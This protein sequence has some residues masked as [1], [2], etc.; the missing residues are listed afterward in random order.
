MAL[1]VLSLTLKLVEC[2]SNDHP[3]YEPINKIGFGLIFGLNSLMRYSN[4]SWN[5]TNAQTLFEYYYKNYNETNIN[6][7]WELGNEPDIYPKQ[8]NYS[9]PNGTELYKDFTKLSE[10]VSKYDTD[11]KFQLH[12][13]DVT[14]GT[15]GLN[16]L[17]L[18]EDFVSSFNTNGPIKNFNTFTFHHQYP[19]LNQ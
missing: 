4:G 13:C 2:G 1:Q 17:Y 16:G 7:H 3:L 19:N 5:S 10:I 11:N 6:I 9:I 15:D 8:F 18:F 12:G 14:T